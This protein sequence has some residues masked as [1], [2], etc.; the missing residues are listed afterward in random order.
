MAGPAPT[1]RPTFTDEQVAT[2]HTLIRRHS[3]PH[4]EVYRAKLALLLHANPALAS[5]AAGRRLGKH[6]NW[7]RSWRRIG[8][9]KGFRLTDRP[10]RG[11]KP[12]VSPPCKR[13]RW[14]PWPANCPP[15]A[16]NPSVGTARATWR[17]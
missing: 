11:R 1:H 8:A 2:C 14:W 9:G 15:S 4:A 6:A 13:R 17:G 10:G 7:V 5:E 3:A 16:P 12:R